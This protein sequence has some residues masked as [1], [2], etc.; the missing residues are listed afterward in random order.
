MAINR[1]PPA[2]PSPG[3]VVPVVKR[4][5]VCEVVPGA[6]G[7]GA[8]LTAR[9]SARCPSRGGLAEQQPKAVSDA[10]NALGHRVNVLRH[11]QALPP[12]GESCCCGSGWSRCR[13]SG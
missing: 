3:S 2:R 13:R 5:N 11:G 8:I 10:V 7:G 6:N 4:W 12:E 1:P 9:L